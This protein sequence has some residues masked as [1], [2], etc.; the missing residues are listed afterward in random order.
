[1][2]YKEGDTTFLYRDCV[3]KGVPNCCVFH[4]R[5][6]A[7]YA[8]IWAHARQSRLDSGLLAVF[9]MRRKKL[10]RFQGLL[11]ESQ[12]HNLAST[13]LNVP[14]SFDSGGCSPRALTIAMG[15]CVR[16]RDSVSVCARERARDIWRGS[17]RESEGERARPS[18][19]GKRRRIVILRAANQPISAHTSCS[20]SLL[21]LQ[22]LEGPRD[23]S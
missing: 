16:E 1:M 10:K 8:P 18:P 22:V 14:Q 9:R 7:S 6:Q 11:P 17:E 5:V 3:V 4:F 15:V 21:S 23:L 20:S 19:P 13:V 2:L 12:G